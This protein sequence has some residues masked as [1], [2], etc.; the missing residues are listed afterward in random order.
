MKIQCTQVKKSIKSLVRR[1]KRNHIRAGEHTAC[2]D[3]EEP[4]FECKF[5]DSLCNNQTRFVEDKYALS[6]E[7]WYWPDLSCQSATTMIGACPDGTFLV[8]RS[9]T[10]GFAF[11]FTYKVGGIVGN[12]RVYC[13]NGLFSLCYDD[14]I[15]PKEPT[16]KLLVERLLTTKEHEQLIMIYRRTGD[17]TKAIPLKLVKPLQRDI[18]LMEHCRKVIMRS[19]DNPEDIWQFH[20][21]M[22]LKVFLL[23]LRSVE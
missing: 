19:L 23:E 12:A 15:Q 18:S 8:R 16:L 10:S 13:K 2:R 14:S 17:C 11:S 20:L 5:I 3:I 4:K 7:S 1:R 9:E 6:T 22:N 21:P